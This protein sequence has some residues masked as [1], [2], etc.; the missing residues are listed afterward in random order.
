MGN[1]EEILDKLGKHSLFIT[2]GVLARFWG[3]RVREQ[4][5]K[6][7]EFHAVWQGHWNLFEFNRMPF[8]IKNGT[9]DFCRMYMKILGPTDDKPEGFIGRRCYVWV[10]DCVIFSSSGGEQLHTERGG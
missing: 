7:L 1:M 5:R 4:D 8:G 10:D 2:Y 3:L 9:S 6:Y